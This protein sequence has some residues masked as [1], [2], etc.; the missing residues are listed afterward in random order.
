MYNLGYPLNQQ[1]LCACRFSGSVPGTGDSNIDEA[2]SQKS[3]SLAE[4][5]GG[6][7]NQQFRHIYLAGFNDS[8]V[9]ELPEKGGLVGKRQVT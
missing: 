1:I 5:W 9:N 2:G 3:S 6:H 4:G 7:T 8:N